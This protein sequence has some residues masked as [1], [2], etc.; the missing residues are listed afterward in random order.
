MN[1]IIT[2]QQVIDLVFIPE[3]LVTRSKITA[4]DIAIAESRYL[5]PIIG[6]AL[7]DA[8]SAGRY[9]E[10]RDEYVAPM[11]AAWTRYIAEPLLAERLGIAQNKDY[12]EADNDVRKDAVRRLRRNAQLLSRRM[13]DYLNAHSDNFAE[14]NPAD[15]P[16]NHC[17]IDGG[18]VQIF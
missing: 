9:T 14:Y 15:N 8:I 17:T 1:S 7:Y 3:T 18:I 2:P 12:S 13:S 6:E 10:L 4:T 5:L 16:L 11:V